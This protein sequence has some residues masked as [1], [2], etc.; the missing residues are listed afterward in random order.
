MAHRKQQGPNTGA[1]IALAALGAVALFTWRMAEE[2][3]QYSRGFVDGIRRSTG[4]TDG[5]FLRSV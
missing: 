4:R 1:V 3:E 5:R 2:S